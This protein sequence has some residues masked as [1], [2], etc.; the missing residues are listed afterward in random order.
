[1]KYLSEQEIL[2][3]LTKGNET[4]YEF[5]FLTFYN[6]LCVYALGIV[7]DKMAAEEIVQDV[8]VKLWESREQLTVKTSLKAYLYR[9]VHNHSINYL[10]HQSIKEKYATSVRNNVDLVSPV[11]ADYPIANLLAQELDE[12][13]NQSLLEL[14][15]QCRAVFLLI[16]YH[17]L[18]YNETAVKLGISVNTV[19]TQLQRAI[20]RLRESLKDYLPTVM[21]IGY[22]LLS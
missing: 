13:I 18:T 4:A 21:A 6:E 15:E 5:V 7:R 2:T 20:S 22:L 9:A 16:R 11:S 19:K 12:K 3:N 10:S 14:P 1:M 17:D 8:F